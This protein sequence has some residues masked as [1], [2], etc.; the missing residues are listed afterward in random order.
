MG[1]LKMLIGWENPLSQGM[2][3]LIARAIRQ[4]VFDQSLHT[5]LCNECYTRGLE[6]F[7]FDR[8]Y[9][10]CA[11]C[12][13]TVRAIGINDWSSVGMPFHLLSTPIFTYTE[14]ES[15]PMSMPSS[16]TV[17]Y[18]RLEDLV[19]ETSTSAGLLYNNTPVTTDNAE[20]TF[21]YETSTRR[22]K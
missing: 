21:E 19:E 15:R 3:T 5:L 16:T 8:G 6:S 1:Q 22:S 17:T 11:E 2:L 12:D 9:I 18:A 20:L 4:G 14:T 7:Y 13:G 10:R